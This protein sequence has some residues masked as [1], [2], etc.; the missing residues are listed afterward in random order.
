MITNQSVLQLLIFRTRYTYITSIRL[1]HYTE[2][3]ERKQRAR[4]F[5]HDYRPIFW[6]AENVSKV[7]EV[8]SLLPSDEE[9][10]MASS[11]VKC[12]PVPGVDQ[13]GLRLLNTVLRVYR[14]S[15]AAVT[16]INIR[17]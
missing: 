5:C 4:T 7:L 15:T 3:L 1:A 13:S 9:W 17:A 14:P 6:T 2:F 16:C 10:V 8:L 11:I 12:P